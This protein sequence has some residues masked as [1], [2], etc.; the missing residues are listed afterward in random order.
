MDDY[1]S[2]DAAIN[3]VFEAFADGRSAY[4]ALEAIPAAGV[5]PKDFHERCLQIEIQKRMELERKADVCP[6]YLPNKHD[7]GND[8]LCRK[9]NIA[10]NSKADVRPVVRGKWIWL[11][12][13][14]DESVGWWICSACNQEHW[15]E[16]DFC[17][18]CG[19]DMREEQT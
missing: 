1:I 9:F 11:E 3:A 18:N 4:I 19:A 2:R 13:P 15:C 10:V 8:S 17:P 16:S 5:V 12:P 7:K 6:Y 14:D